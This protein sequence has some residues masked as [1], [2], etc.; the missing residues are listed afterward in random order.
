M[1][2][3]YNLAL[4]GMP[5]G[6][7]LDELFPRGAVLAVREP[8]YKPSAN[9]TC[10]VVRIE[11]P[12]DYEILSPQHALAKGAK[13]ATATLGSPRPASFDFKALGNRYFVAKKD[14]LAVKAYSDGLAASDDAAKRLV[15]FLNRSQAHLRLGN[16]ASALRDTSAVLGF[17]ASDITAPALAELKATLRRAKAFEGLR[18]LKSAR[19]AYGRVLEL[20]ATSADALASVQRVERMLH[21]SAT[22]EY[23]WRQIVKAADAGVK[24]E[25]AVGDYVGPVQ[26]V[27]LEGRGGGRGVVATRDIKAGELLLG[28]S[29]P[30]LI[31]LRTLPFESSRADVSTSSLARSRE[32]LRDG[33]DGRGQHR[34]GL[35]LRA[36]HGQQRVQDGPRRG[37]R[38]QDPGRPV[39]CGAPVRASRRRDRQAHRIGR[40][41]GTAGPRGRHERRTRLC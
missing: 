27:E 7:D 40:P 31:S 26:V 33:R 34:H 21:E 11:S 3:I 24:H 23:D 4:H 25:L 39:G 10:N 1:L 8:T 38:R 36:Q 14:L 16:F 32:G 41:R 13:W 28:A 20:D 19:E 17:L 18:Q 12:T 9:G 6:P 29:S 22:G 37:V 2:A 30:S 15:L 35:R 5:T